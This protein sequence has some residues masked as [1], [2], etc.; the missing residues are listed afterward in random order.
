MCQNC[1]NYSCGGC[2]QSCYSFPPPPGPVGPQGP[3]GPQGPAGAAGAQGIQG[4]PGTNGLPGP[5]GNPGPAGPPGPPG[6]VGPIN[7]VRISSFPSP[8]Y[9]VT[10]AEDVIL[11]NSSLGV[12]TINLLAA[13]NALAGRNTLT[14]KDAFGQAGLNDIIINPLFPDVIDQAGGSTSLFTK[15]GVYG[16]LTLVSN[17]LGVGGAWSII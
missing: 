5:Q 13:G 11:V 14:I 12:V 6:T 1:N 10:G 4:V 3:T 15:V 17:K 2:Q 7:V 9:N 8:V 16:S